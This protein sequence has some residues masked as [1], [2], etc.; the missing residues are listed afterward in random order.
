M[1]PECRIIELVLACLATR[2]LRAANSSNWLT[3]HV[4]NLTECAVHWASQ[5]CT[6]N[7]CTLPERMKNL[8][9]SNAQFAPQRSHNQLTISSLDAMLT[10]AFVDGEQL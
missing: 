4:R 3:H 6:C 9:C 7:D 10:I 5:S 8:C 2:G 1:C